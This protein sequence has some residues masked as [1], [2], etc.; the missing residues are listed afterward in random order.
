M[1]KHAPS[2]Q[3]PIHT[4]AQAEAFLLSLVREHPRPYAS[5]ALE[6]ITVLLEA[7]DNPHQEL[8][9]L[10]IAGSKGKG[11][12]ALMCEALFAA[13]GL[14]TATYTSP[15]LRRWTERIRIGGKEITE[16]S[17]IFTLERIRKILQSLTQDSRHDLPSFFDVLSAAAFI[18]FKEAEVDLAIIE[19]GLGGRYDASNVISADLCCITSIE[20]EHMDKL[21]NNIADVAWHKAGI[22]KS[23]CPVVCGNMPNEALERIEEQALEQGAPLSLIGRDF[24]VQTSPNTVT[25]SSEQ[26]SLHYA[27]DGLELTFLLPCFGRHMA[28]NAALAITLLNLYAQ[29]HLS[30]RS[31]NL[32]SS[33]KCLSLL[34][35]PGRGQI[36]SRQP[37][38]L[39][40]AAHTPK[41][42]ALL[43]QHLDTLGAK[44][45][46]FLVAATHG[47]DL[48]ALATLITSAQHVYVTRVDPMRSMTAGEL[49]TGL[50]QYSP[51][52][53]M[54]VI[55]DPGEALSL[56]RKQLTS[57]QILCICGSVYLA[58][59][60]LEHLRNAG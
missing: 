55:E 24:L 37:L 31:I 60:A 29:Q 46:C 6:G 45:R 15:H 33:V 16:N 49:A 1:P 36:V 19:C 51:Q 58:G 42:L 11:S 17:F 23:N 47:K 4:P 35:L 34:S 10:H 38:I 50:A 8:N 32:H 21:G 27:G 48:R 22:I 39:V 18:L 12:V 25:Q 26:Q 44:E 7:F 14:H 5:H 53:E 56:V 28:E 30:S 2:L 52:L 43:G 3:Q 13:Y 59:F 41:S 54:T 20:L 9:C 40:D 57:E